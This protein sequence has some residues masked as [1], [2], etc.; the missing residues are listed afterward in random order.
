MPSKTSGLVGSYFRTGD[1]PARLGIV[2]ERPKAGIYFVQ[3]LDAGNA[4]PTGGRLVKVEAMQ[5]WSF[6]PNLK[7]LW[8]TCSEDR[9]A[10]SDKTPPV[11]PVPPPS[12][13][14]P[15]LRQ[16]QHEVEPERVTCHAK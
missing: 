12:D 11:P 6:Y 14:A 2:A 7:L 13:P 16:G 5:S 15:A 4:Q 10:A 9:P 3:F 8:R 1:T